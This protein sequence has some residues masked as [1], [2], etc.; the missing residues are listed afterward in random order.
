MP[1]FISE[2]AQAHDGSMLMAHS[3]IESSKKAGFD[4]VKF[5]AHFAEHESSREEKFRIQLP[6]LAD[7]SRY[8]YWKRMEFDYHQLCEL[9]SHSKDLDLDHICSPFSEYAVDVLEKAGVDVYKIGSGEFY[10]LQLI[11]LVLKTN[12]KV[13]ISTGMSSWD[14]INK[15]NSYLKEFYPREYSNVIFFHCTT[16]YPCPIEKIGIKN[17]S[18]LKASIC[19]DKVGFSDHSGNSSTILA[20]Y[21]AGANFFEFHTIFSKDI[22]GFDSSSSITFNEAGK[23]IQEIKYIELLNSISDD[24]DKIS[25]TLTDLKL[26]F[27]KSLYLKMDLAK[28]TKLEKFHLQLKKPAIGIPFEKIELV[29]G[30]KLNKNMFSGDLIKLEDLL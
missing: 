1:Y 18:K 12:K 30:R 25:E 14:E 10:N 24:K 27:S 19:A 3:M 5:Q 7:K 11:E 2:V 17:I 23:L 15:M 4:A 16:S 6:Y 26:N 8:E 21:F 13:F 9:Y 22:I 28:G 29:L 20:G